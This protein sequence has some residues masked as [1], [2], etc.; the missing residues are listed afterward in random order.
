MNVKNIALK[1]LES[2]LFKMIATFIFN[3]MDLSKNIE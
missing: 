3:P 2:D 1:S